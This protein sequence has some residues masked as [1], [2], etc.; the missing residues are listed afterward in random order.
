MDKLFHRSRGYYLYERNETEIWHFE[1]RAD[2]AD[3]SLVRPDG[4]QDEVPDLQDPGEEQAQH[5]DGV[6]AVAM[7]DDGRVDDGG[8]DVVVVQEEEVEE[9]HVEERLGQSEDATD[10]DQQPDHVPVSM[11]GDSVRWES[12][13][14]KQ[15]QINFI[16]NCFNT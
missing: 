10:E 11:F 16:W 12:L 15:K 4:D 2:F 9:G 14:Q 1:D 6:G 7:L 8:G 13:R 3:T 5:A